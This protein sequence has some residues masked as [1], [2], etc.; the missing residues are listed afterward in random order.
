M[1]RTTATAI[2]H[3]ITNTAVESDIQSGIIK[4]DISDHFPIFCVFPL[5]ER[6]VLSKT[7]TEKRYFSQENIDTFKFLLENIK[8]NQLLPTNSPDKAYDI[9]LKVFYDLYETAFPKKI[10][11]IK[12]KY[13][14][15]PWITRGLQKSSKRK[16]RLYEKF[17]K[18]RTKKKKLFIKIIRTCLKN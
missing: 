4:S 10:I 3:I 14:E 7:R 15:T 18:K 2:D 12:T 8:W 9:F 11:E 16:Q 6:N 1:T 5:K 13:L 17:L